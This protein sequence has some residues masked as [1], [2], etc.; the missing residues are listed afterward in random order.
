MKV[1]WTPAATDITDQEIDRYEALAPLVQ[2]LHQDVQE[3]AK[4]KQDGALTKVR[5]A[6]IN[7]LLNDVKEF[8]KNQPSAVYLDLLDEA[9]VPQNADALLIVGQYLAALH[10]YQDRYTYR[11]KTDL[12]WKWATTRASEPPPKQK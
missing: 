5:I 4:K 7:R 9:T 11:D 6:L 3:L 10:H 2:S 12:Q 8:L 1:R